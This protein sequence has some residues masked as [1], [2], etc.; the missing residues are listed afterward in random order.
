M[1]KLRDDAAQLSLCFDHSC[2]PLHEEGTKFVEASNV[3][4]LDFSRR[5]KASVLS[6]SDLEEKKI[7]EEVLLEARKL[8]W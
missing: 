6:C 3:V 4:N 1:T 5:T 8:K 7:L 2:M